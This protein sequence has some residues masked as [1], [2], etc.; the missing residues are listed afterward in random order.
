MKMTQFR[1]MIREIIDEE[2][3]LESQASDDAKSKGLEYYEFGRW[4]KDGK[5]TYVTQKGKLVPVKNKAD[6]DL[7]SGPSEPKSPEQQRAANQ[8]QD[9]LGD[10]HRRAIP[11]AAHKIP[12]VQNAVID[13]L[14]SLDVN[15]DGSGGAWYWDD[16]NEVY[17]YDDQEGGFDYY[18]SVKPLDNDE[19]EIRDG[20]MH[21]GHSSI[22]PVRVTGI[23]NVMNRLRP[24]PI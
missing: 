17:E 16:K 8:P 3:E 22:K 11:R 15:S 14:E 12:K 9:T 13:K 23:A 5:T 18:A 4:G 24:M 7:R 20:S 6:A 1:Q 2:L 19:Y 21:G 10:P